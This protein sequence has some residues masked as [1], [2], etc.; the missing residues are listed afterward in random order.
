MSQGSISEI[1]DVIKE[2]KYYSLMDSMR[3][4]A[5]NDYKGVSC[6]MDWVL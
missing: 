5:K 3:K 4:K 6:P 1:L 2:K